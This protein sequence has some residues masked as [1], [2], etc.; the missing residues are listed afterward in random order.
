MA[1]AERE[2][3]VGSRGKARPYRIFGAFNMFYA[4]LGILFIGILFPHIGTAVMGVKSSG[5]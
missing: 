2:S 5:L 1:S 4:F 3:P